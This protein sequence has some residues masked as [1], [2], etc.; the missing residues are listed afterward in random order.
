MTIPTQLSLHGFIATAPEL[1][2]P[3]TKDAGPRRRRALAQ[4]ARRL[5]HQARPDVPQPRD[6]R[7][8]RQARLR[9]IPCR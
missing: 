9:P 1:S 7:R 2:K 4:G 6:V 3:D 5:V 8:V